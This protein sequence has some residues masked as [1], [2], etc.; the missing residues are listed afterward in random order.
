MKNNAL[1]FLRYAAV[2]G[3]SALVD[4]G[5]LY[6]LTEFVFFGKKDGLALSLSV[7]GGFLAG[8]IVNYLLSNIFVFT[9]K[10][11]RE[12]G[13]KAG[14]FFIYALVGIVGFLLTELLM[15]LGMM[16]VNHEGLWYILLNCFVKGV[17][18]IWNYVGRKIF[19]YKGE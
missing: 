3:I 1:E 15:H 16:I 19:V 12:K 17:V 9:S 8:L 4:M 6:L 7:A 14:A 11:Q 2:G 13:K 5:V 10:L 18:L